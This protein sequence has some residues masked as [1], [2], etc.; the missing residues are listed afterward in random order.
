[1][2]AFILMLLLL[3]SCAP[4]KVISHK[5]KVHGKNRIVRSY[6]GTATPCYLTAYHVVDGQLSVRVEDAWGVGDHCYVYRLG[7]DVALLVPEPGAR[8]K[9]GPGDSGTVY[10]WKGDLYV[11]GGPRGEKIVDKVE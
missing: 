2:R 5:E 7:K 1:M 4:Y 9:L 3:A 6:Y 10:M 8:E 11:Y